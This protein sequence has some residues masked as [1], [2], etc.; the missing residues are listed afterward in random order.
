M[1][2]AGSSLNDMTRVTASSPEMWRDICLENRAALLTQIEAY[3]Q[4][5]SRLQQMLAD[6]DGESLEKLFAEARAIRQDWSAFRN[7]S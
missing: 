7:K 3:Q 4:E 1:R 2:L 6:H 5:L